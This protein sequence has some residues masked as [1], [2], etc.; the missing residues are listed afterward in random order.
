MSFSP[1]L[2]APYTINAENPWNPEKDGWSAARAGAQAG[3]AI[4][5]ACRRE[6]GLANYP[7]RADSPYLTGLKEGK[8]VKDN[9]SLCHNS[10][11]TEIFS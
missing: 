10:L 1:H 2:F 4:R 6:T 3:T 8:T 5:I 11:Q 7:A 9:P